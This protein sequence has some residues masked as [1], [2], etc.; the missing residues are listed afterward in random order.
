M[1][2]RSHNLRRVGGGNNNFNKLLTFVELSKLP[3]GG[4]VPAK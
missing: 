3:E 1:T 2:E 4:T